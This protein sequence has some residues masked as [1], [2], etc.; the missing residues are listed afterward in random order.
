MINYETI[1]SLFDDKLTLLQY[2]TKI[3]EA[4][5][6]EKL[7]DITVTQTDAS[8]VYFTFVFEDGSTIDTPTFTLPQ[9]EQ[10]EQGIQG[11]SV[12]NAE[13]DASGHLILTLSNGNTI[14][15]GATGLQTVTASDVDSE[16][17]TQYEV[18]KADGN[19]GASWGRVTAGDIAD[20]NQVGQ[21]LGSTGYGFAGWKKFEVSGGQINSYAATQGQ[22]LTADGNGG[23]GWE[24][25]P[26]Q[27]PEGTAIKSTGETSG[28]VLTAD[29]SG[30]ASWQTAGGGGT[31]LT[32]YTWTETTWNTS[33]EST[34]KSILKNAKGNVLGHLLIRF[35]VAGGNKNFNINIKEIVYDTNYSSYLLI[36]DSQACTDG[37]SQYILLLSIYSYNHVWTNNGCLLLKQDGTVTNVTA[38]PTFMSLYVEYYNDEQLHP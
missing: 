9:G 17:A 7:T 34:L 31:T 21:Y 11:V 30:G 27:T 22:V 35:N 38:S 2:L 12:T 28:K 10:G 23:A 24:T 15:A 5:K 20:N 8:H 3:D 32:K 25:I 37:T 36:N 16:T 1:L 29:G 18:L 6:N 13:I 14:D 26:A 33:A 4:L 19:G